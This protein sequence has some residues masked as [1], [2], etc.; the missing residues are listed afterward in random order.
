M[1][2]KDLSRMSRN[3]TDEHLFREPLGTSRPKNGADVAAFLG[4]HREAKHTKIR[5]T[6]RKDEGLLGCSGRTTLR[7]RQCDGLPIRRSSLLP[8]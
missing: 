6:P 5:K 8:V 2:K 4:L 1:W 7:R 3:G